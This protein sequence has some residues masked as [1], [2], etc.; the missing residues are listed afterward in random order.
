MQTQA[1]EAYNLL[2]KCKKD[3]DESKIAEKVWE[4]YNKNKEQKIKMK[5][6]G[7]GKGVDEMEPCD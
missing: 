2:E 7:K 4:N 3:L 5:E 6:E 1:N